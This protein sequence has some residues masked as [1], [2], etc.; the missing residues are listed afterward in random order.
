MKISYDG[1]NEIL[2]VFLEELRNQ[3]KVIEAYGWKPLEF[4]AKKGSYYPPILKKMFMDVYTLRVLSAILKGP[5]GGGKTISLGDIA[6]TLFL[7]KGFDVLIGSGGEEQSKEVYDEVTKVLDIDDEEVAAQVIHQTMQ[8]TRGR[9]G[10]W[11]RFIP[12]STRRARGPHPGRGHGAVIILDEEGEMIEAVVKAILGT[13]STAYPLIILRASTAHNMDGTYADLMEHH[14]ERG[15]K[16]YEWDAFDVCKKCERR[17]EECIPEFREDYCRGKAHNNSILGWISLDFLFRMWEE[18]TKE[19]FEVEMMGRK[20]SGASRVINPDDFKKALVDEAPFVREAPGAFGIDWGFK[21][22]TK[23]VATQMVKREAE[24]SI[25]QV[26]DCMSF[27]RTGI[28]DITGAL[29]NW[30]D[31]YGID[32]V[33]ADSSHPFE[34]DAV[35]KAGFTVHEVTFVSFKEAGASA[36]KWF[37]EKKRIEIPR[38]FRELVEQLRKWRR[39]KT[40]KIVKKDDHYPDALLCTMM[41][42]WNKARRRVGYT[43]AVKK[44]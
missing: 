11:I 15:Y 6:A 22:F 37:F 33:F 40:G 32:E 4:L 36:V 3:D 5:R 1:K 21:G 13:G 43:K 31:M 28:E 30:R 9:R 25:L 41:K 35:R 17:C 2:N 7:F 27:S 29:K 34:N 19:W 42:W 38:H 12:A 20:P 26:F 16:L 24:E 39:D 10:N 18:E 23:V 8:I 14:E 44:R